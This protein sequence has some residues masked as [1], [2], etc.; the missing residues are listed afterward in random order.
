MHAPIHMVDS[1]KNDESDDSEIVEF[2]G[3]YITCALTD[4][5]KYPEMSNLVKRVQTHHHTT[6]CRK[7]KI[8]AC[9]FNAPW[10]S[11]DKTRIVRC[12][13]KINEIIVK[14]S[15]KHIEKVLS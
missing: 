12:E 1:S 7:K 3:K 4:A 11:S 15:K 8:V 10:P 9:R 13:E 6:A 2:I 5:T 14:Q